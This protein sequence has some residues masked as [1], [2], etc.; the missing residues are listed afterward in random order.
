MGVRRALGRP[1]GHR[2]PPLGTDPDG[3]RCRTRGMG[4]NNG[5]TLVS[6]ESPARAF[7]RPRSLKRCRG[8]AALVGE[9]HVRA[10]ARPSEKARETERERVVGTGTPAICAWRN[11]GSR[12]LKGNLY[13]FRQLLS[14]PMR[15]P[16]AKVGRVT[17]SRCSGCPCSSRETVV[18]ETPAKRATSAIV[19]ME[20]LLGTIPLLGR[21]TA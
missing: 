13:C 12:T 9:T 4:R 21:N 17:A 10:G 15:S 20:P 5:Q 14:P 16:V 8:L 7:S 11:A 6:A 18:F 19:A 2:R 1:R 3:A